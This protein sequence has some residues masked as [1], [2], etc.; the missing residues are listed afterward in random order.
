MVYVYYCYVLHSF[1]CCI[2]ACLWNG[3]ENFDHT[4]ALP[5]L[6]IAHV[7]SNS[8]RLWAPLIVEWVIFLVCLNR[9]TACF[10]DVAKYADNWQTRDDDS[11]YT[12][13]LKNI[14]QDYIKP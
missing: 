3:K 6:T 4:E 8:D 14:P 1:V 10:A 5:R 7:E 9:F 13:M 2:N 11:C 12:C